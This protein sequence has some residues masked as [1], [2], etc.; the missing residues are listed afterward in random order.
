[1]IDFVVIREVI[2]QDRLS[3][4]KFVVSFSDMSKTSRT[5]VSHTYVCHSKS[6]TVTS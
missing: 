5:I 1:M 3:D 2:R 6:I 4:N